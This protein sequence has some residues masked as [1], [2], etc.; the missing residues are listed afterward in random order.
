M[1]KI[2]ITALATGAFVAGIAAMSW[3]QVPPPMATPVPMM[4]PVPMLTPLPMVTPVP[5]PT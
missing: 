4:T 2:V 1:Q 3:A 5:L